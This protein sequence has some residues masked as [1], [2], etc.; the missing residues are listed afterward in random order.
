MALC[1]GSP[2]K[3]IQGLKF[4]LRLARK[5][6]GPAWCLPGRVLSGD[7]SWRTGCWRAVLSIWCNEPPGLS[8]CTPV[9]N[10]PGCH[11]CTTRAAFLASK[12]SH[13]SSKL[14]SDFLG[15]AQIW[16]GGQAVGT[17]I[18]VIILKKKFTHVIVP[19]KCFL[20]TLCY[21]LNSTC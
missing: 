4:T 6:W 1:Y 11:L 17:F 18:E 13:S 15:K 7:A 3:L 5:G 8:S 9:T 2:S 16:G 19:T 20:S 10:A 21:Y 14:L 12:S